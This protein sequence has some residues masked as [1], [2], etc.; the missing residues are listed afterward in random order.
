MATFKKAAIKDI[1]VI[2]ELAYKIWHQ[3]Y[4]GIISVDQVNYMLQLMYSSPTLNR[5]LMSEVIYELVLDSQVDQQV[6]VG[7]FSYQYEKDKNR[8]KLNKLYLLPEFHGQ[9]IG[10]LMLSHV[11]AA[12]TRYKAHQIYLTVNKDNQQ[13]IKAYKK[14]GFAITESMV[15]DIGGGHVMDDF[16]MTYGSVI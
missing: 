14:F 12:G 15:N 11:K 9:G 2:Q 1:P 4:P 3:Y 13:A 6:T 7:F 8:V 10:Q 16:I 5:E